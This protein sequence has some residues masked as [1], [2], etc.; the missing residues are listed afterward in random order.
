[1][2]N[3]RKTELT[4]KDDVPLSDIL[5]YAT[6]LID[7]YRDAPKGFL[8]QF[9]QEVSSRVF[10]QR[11]GDMTW[12]EVAEMEHA[13]TG[14]LDSKQMAF[15]VKSYAR[16]LGF[17]R[18]FI[19]DNPSEL[20]REEL[21]ELTKGA[22]TKDFEISFDVVKNGIADGSQLWFTPP[23]H[24]AYSFTD[25]HNHTFPD[26][27]T[28][29]GSTGPY[30]VSEHVREANKQLRHHGKSPSVALV[31][32]NIAAE[33]I[34][35]R[36]DGTNYYIPEAEGLREGA[37]PEQTLR[38]DGTHFV[39]TAWLDGNDVFI[40]S[41]SRPIKTNTVRPIEITDNSGVPVGGSGGSYGDPGALI[42]AYGSFR[43][44]AKMADPL[45]GVKFTADN[46]A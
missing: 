31:S 22:D 5:G 7:E 3:Y 13:K 16:S 25:T 30:T 6:T 4:T 15:S 11:T 20:L 37:L 34:S 14:T 17:S 1:M 40:M 36:T 33:L 18:E 45:A 10:M 2:A 43:K 19:E 44:G 21:R 29:F 24:G 32:S 27:N 8:N 39:Q 26:T 12:N 38:E 42:G 35:E 9:T 46:L 41:D 23:D 28:L